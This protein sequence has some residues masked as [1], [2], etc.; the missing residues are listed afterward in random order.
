MFPRLRDEFDAFVLERLS[1]YPAALRT[2]IP[3]IIV[4][5]HRYP[6]DLVEGQMIQ[7]IFRLSFHTLNPSDKEIAD[8]LR[9]DWTLLHLYNTHFYNY[10]RRNAFST[11][12]EDRSRAGQ[13]FVDS[14]SYA[15]TRT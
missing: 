13:F 3:T 5:S 7:D 6:A 11:L 9:L 14:G 4:Y 12:F 8:G 1:Q 10:S 15:T 2:L